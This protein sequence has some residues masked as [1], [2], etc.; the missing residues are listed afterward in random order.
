MLN[1][2]VYVYK[3]EEIEITAE[4]KIRPVIHLY[5]VRNIKIAIIHHQMCDVYRVH[6]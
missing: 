3:V 6:I 2:M 5:N 1:T 4:C